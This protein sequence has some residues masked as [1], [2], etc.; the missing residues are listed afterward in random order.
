MTNTQTTT[1]VVGCKISHTTVCITFL[2]RTS[3][4]VKLMDG[5]SIVYSLPKQKMTVLTLPKAGIVGLKLVDPNGY[6]Y[7]NVGTQTRI[8]ILPTD[9]ERVPLSKW[10]RLWFWPV[11]I[12]FIIGAIV[13]GV[14]SQKVKE[15]NYK[16]FCKE[17]RG[18]GSGNNDAD[19]SY[20][21]D[22]IQMG[23]TSSGNGGLIFLSVFCGIL[24]IALI[25]L[26]LFAFGPLS[27]D[28][29][30]ETCSKKEGFGSYW[31]WVKPRSKW[32]A[33]LCSAFGACECAADGLGMACNEGGTT[34]EWQYRWD[35]KSARKSSSPSN[36]CFCC[37]GGESGASCISPVTQNICS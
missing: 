22:R 6:D 21:V 14:M 34:S 5:S 3:D 35:E 30:Y 37:V 9:K 10:K 36:V 25:V 32:R 29:S 16:S 12:L 24:A 33:F 8:L 26:W 15:N 13:A 11:I 27:P 23:E 4:V 18:F 31:K 19:T 17:D 1:P 28:V 7:G 2:N 20:C